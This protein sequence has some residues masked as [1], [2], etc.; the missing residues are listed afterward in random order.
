MQQPFVR[1]EHVEKSYDGKQLV[2]RD[3]TLDIAQ[4][5]FLTL[6]GPSGSGKTT[7][8]MMLAGFETATSGEIYLDGKPINRIAPEHRNIGMVFQSYALF[9]HMTVAENVGFPLRVRGITGEAAHSRVMAA[10]DKVGLKGLESRRPAQMSGGQQQRVAVARAL[11]FEP[12]LVLMDEPLS[13]LD[14]QLREQLQ[15]EIKRLH[16]DLGITIVYVTHDQTEALAM[17]DRIAV[18]HHGRIQQIDIPTQLYERPANAFVAQFIGENNTL[19]GTVHSAT[20]SSCQIALADGTLI[21]GQAVDTP[22]LGAHKLVS[23]R[24]ERVRISPQTQ[25]DGNANVVKATVID[26]TYLGRYARLRLKACGLEDF[27]VTLPNDGRDL[28]LAGGNT[29]HIGWDAAD[30]RVLDSE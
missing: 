11:V 5:E 23:I 15:Y 24:P 3:L 27:I 29:I 9:P 16:S 22:A 13:A 18:F 25:G 6:L 14:K 17:S 28:A 30:C 26:I 2:V 12:K 19:K 7:T 4:G 20:G 8:L 1:F 10:L 21:H